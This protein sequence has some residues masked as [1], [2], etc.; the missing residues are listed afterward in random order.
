MKH[1]LL[2]SYKGKKIEGI[3][4]RKRGGKAKLRGISHYQIGIMVAM[5]GDKN[6]ISDVYG[7]GR[8]TTQQAEDVLGNKIEEDSILVTDSHK[9]YIQFAKNHNLQHKRIAR[10]KHKNGEYHINNVSNYHKGLKDFVRHFNG[11]ST[12][13]LTNYL[14]WFSW[15]KSGADNNLLIKDCLFG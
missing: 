14:N 3:E 8:L 6:I 5:D 9:S 15:I 13:Y 1:F 2:E 11:I 4:G 10:G 12:R 7:I